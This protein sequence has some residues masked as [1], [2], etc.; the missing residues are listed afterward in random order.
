MT[1]HDSH[2]D[3]RRASLRAPEEIKARLEEMQREL[4]RRPPVVRPA[5]DAPDD[6]DEGTRR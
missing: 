3:G 1:D 2:R 4:E 6:S 5:G